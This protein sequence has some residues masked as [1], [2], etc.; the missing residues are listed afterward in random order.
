MVSYMTRLKKVTN[1]WSGISRSRLLKYLH[2]PITVLYS[3]ANYFVCVYSFFTYN[4]DDGRD[5]FFGRKSFGAH[6]FTAINLLSQIWRTIAKYLLAI[7]KKNLL[8]FMSTNKLAL[9]HGAVATDKYWNF[10][11]TSICRICYS[12]VRGEQNNII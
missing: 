4:S 2:V 7:I 3:S 12:A 8:Q 6:V 1:V 11:K 10:Y 9:N 5:N